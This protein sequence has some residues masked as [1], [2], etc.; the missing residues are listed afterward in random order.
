M[1]AIV[2]GSS[3]GL[4]LEIVKLLEARGRA[5]VGVSRQ[6]FG[7]AS[8]RETALRAVAEAERRGPIDLLVNCAGI[9]IYKPV[10]SYDDGDI[11][12]MIEAN[13]LA[14]IVFCEALAPRFMT[15]GG[16]IVNVLSTAALVG[17][18]NETVYC[19]AKWGARGYSEALRN[20]AKGTKLREVAAAIVDALE[21]P[22][23]VSELVITR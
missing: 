3:S 13:L 11:A 9:G 15:D 7:D 5:V 19:A 10:G 18:P 16:T 2:T 1:S 17:K 23:L 8:K 20:E 6:T 12:A 22:V 14:T 4:G 21:R